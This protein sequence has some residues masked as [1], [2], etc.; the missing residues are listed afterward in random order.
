ML[1]VD[2]NYIK[3]SIMEHEGFR[4]TIYVCT[5]GHR[6]VGWGHKCVEDH[7]EDRVAYPLGYLRDVFMVDFDKAKKQMKEFLAQEDL[8]IKKE[9]EYI[10]VEMIFQM[11]KNGVSKFR[12]MIKALR[13]QNY[14]LASVEMLDS[15]WY[16]QTPN[17]AKK[18]SDLMASLEG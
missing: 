12:N 10:L 3:E 5:E 8:A 15:L 18:L 9:A 4:D 11:G 14:G 16:K 7:W 17:R 6:T 13:G 1:K 2:E